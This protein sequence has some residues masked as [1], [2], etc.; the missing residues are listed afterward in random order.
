ME[1]IIQVKQCSKC[2]IEKQLLE[3]SKWTKNRDGYKN[4]CKSCQSKYWLNYRIENDKEL[5]NKRKVSYWNN[6]EENRAKQRIQAKK[7]REKRRVQ[8]KKYR[9]KNRDKINSI[10]RAY[11]QKRK[12]DPNFYPN[13]LR[14]KV[15]GRVSSLVRISLKGNKGG[16]SWEELVGYNL[17]TL[18]GNLEKLF[19]SNMNLEELKKGNIVVD[20]IL[21]RELFEYKTPKNPQF[22]A[23]WALSNLQPLWKEDND[24]KSDLLP[25]GRRARYL[26]K[27]E[28]LDYLKSLGYNF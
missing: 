8:A 19:T 28:K 9:N 27:Q 11:K 18:M 15:D 21:P 10:R 3:F 1:D 4:I 17:D 16:R 24:K 12:N 25:D 23:C 20:H 6:V 26:T 13:T 14:G 2:S 7:D 22:K 5:K